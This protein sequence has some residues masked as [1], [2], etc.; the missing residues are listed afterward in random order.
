MPRPRKKVVI[1]KN[2]GDSENIRIKDNSVARRRGTRGKNVT[3]SDEENN[4]SVKSAETSEE[5]NSVKNMGAKS[6]GKKTLKPVS[7]QNSESESSTSISNSETSRGRKSNRNSKANSQETMTK[8]LDEVKERR[9][10]RGVKEIKSVTIEKSD[11]PESINIEVITDPNSVEKATKPKRGVTKVNSVAKEKNDQPKD[12]KA[13]DV[14]KPRRGV[15]EVDCDKPE[16]DK[17]SQAQIVS[18]PRRSGRSKSTQKDSDIHENHSSDTITIVKKSPRK[19]KLSKVKIV[20]ALE[21]PMKKV[22]VEATA[23]AAI[24][25][26]SSAVIK[27]PKRRFTSIASSIAKNGVVTQK[28]APRKTLCNMDILGLLDDEVEA[29]EDININDKVAEKKDEEVD[30]EI[31][32]REQI[33]VTNDDKK[34]PVWRR[35]EKSKVSEDVNVSKGVD[36]YDIPQEDFGPED[37]NVGKKKAKR[38]KKDTKAIL[39]FNDKVSKDV[40]NAVKESHNLLTPGLKKSRKPTNLRSKKPSKKDLLDLPPLVLSPQKPNVVVTNY[41]SEVS[42]GAQNYFDSV[43]NPPVDQDNDRD[44]SGIF[45][46]SLEIPSRNYKTP[47]IPKK[48]SRLHENSSTPTQKSKT[49]ALSVKEQIKN[50]FGFDSEEDLR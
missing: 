43:I 5:M 27:S 6:R 16:S 13:E 17:N 29:E 1:E 33:S 37:K 19:R 21:S 42:H 40:R 34:V 35:G 9:P 31:S 50:N 28:N 47:S 39:T 41:D 20:D 46:N 8:S 11:K 23:S 10:K 30:P 12:F 25:G 45:G 24:G 22:R 14:I 4:D 15:K 36:V 49:P 44:R 18:G 7:N 32:F 3:G 48:L 38:K 26:R 2:L